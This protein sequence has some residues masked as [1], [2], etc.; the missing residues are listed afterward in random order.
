MACNFNENLFKP[1]VSMKQK[2]F[3]AFANDWLLVPERYTKVRGVSLYSEK[4]NQRVADIDV[5]KTLKLFDTENV[6]LTGL[7]IQG[8]FIIG[9][10]R[11][12]Y[13]DATYKAWETKYAIKQ[14]MN[15]PVSDLEIN[16]VY[17]TGCGDLFV[18]LGEIYRSTYKGFHFVNST[19]KEAVLNTTKI[20]KS[21]VALL[22]G[23]TGEL[24]TYDMKLKKV[25]D[26]LFVKESYITS[27]VSFEDIY[28]RDKTL[29]YFSPIKPDKEARPVLVLD[30]DTD[31]GS[32]YNFVKVQGDILGGVDYIA[33]GEI[34]GSATM[35]ANLP[36]PEVRSRLSVSFNT[37]DRKTFYNKEV[38]ACYRVVLK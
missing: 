34:Y 33:D 25:T 6:N 17:E 30:I 12:L 19:N 18:Y 29:C 23:K 36:F 1:F 20:N 9:N 15:I 11:T 7:K 5:Y 32:D 24:L 13:T 16:K 27:K 2:V 4:L 38:Q 14:T 3:P 10:D 8:N 21:K 37:G 22:V 26:T 31:V 35:Y 28:K